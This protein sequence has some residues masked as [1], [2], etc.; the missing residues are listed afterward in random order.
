M[1]LDE[2]WVANEYEVQRPLW[3]RLIE[4]EDNRPMRQK[5]LLQALY[6][7]AGVELQ[8][9]WRLHQN[10]CCSSTNSILCG[11]ARRAVEIDDYLFRP[12]DHRRLSSPTCQRGFHQHLC[13]SAAS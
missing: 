8:A 10:S 5:E 12:S 4:T 7:E 2:N 11:G 9:E 13:P 1:S 3:I 6:R